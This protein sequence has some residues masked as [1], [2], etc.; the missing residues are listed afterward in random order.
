MRLPVVIAAL[1]T[2]S[3]FAGQE[4]SL[5]VTPPKELAKV[6]FFLGKWEGTEK[7]PDAIG[8]SVTAKATMVGTKAI[9]DMYF[10]S[11]HV[12]DLGKMG[13]MQGMHLISY[14]TFKKKY[15]AFWFDSSTP[16]VMEMSGDFEG[17]KLIMVSKP[18]EVPGMAQNLIMRATWQ[19]L[20]QNKLSF[21][22]EMQAGDKW[23]TVI[24]GS[25]KKV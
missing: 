15:T 2:T 21:L 6:D 3:A 9:G 24:D 11:N 7:M 1:L 18:T 13:K 10:Q 14:D 22:L 17:D 25:F 8:Q 23:Q 5:N 4:P 20:P 12:A 16:G 19:R